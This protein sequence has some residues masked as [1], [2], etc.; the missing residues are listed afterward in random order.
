MDKIRSSENYQDILEKLAFQRGFLT[1]LKEV[2]MSSETLEK[3]LENIDAII[4]QMS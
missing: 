3:A 4:I 1:L 2:G